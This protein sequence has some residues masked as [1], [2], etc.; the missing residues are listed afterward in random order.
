MKTRTL[1]RSHSHLI[2]S[3]LGLGCM[4]MSWSSWLRRRPERPRHDERGRL[5]R[6]R[7]LEVQGKFPLVLRLPARSTA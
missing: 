6:V 7:G 3:E 4:G 1:G 5:E 2:V